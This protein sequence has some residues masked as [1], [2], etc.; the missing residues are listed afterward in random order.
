MGR[1]HPTAVVDPRA[2]LAADVTVGPY[3]IVEPGVVLA[4]GCE[5]HAHAVVRGPT[6]LGPRCVVHPFAVVGGEP[7]AKRHAGGPARLVGWM[8]GPVLALS[9][10]GAAPAGDRPGLAMVSVEAE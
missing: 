10:P 2:E 8:D 7:Q 9:L 1:I 5:L 6:T 4:D 3:A